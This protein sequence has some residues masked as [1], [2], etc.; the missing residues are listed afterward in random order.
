LYECPYARS[1][2]NYAWFLATCP[3][4][5]FRDPAQS[6]RLAQAATGLAPESAEYWNTLGVARYRSGQWKEALAALDHSCQLA[7]GGTAFDFY[8][9]AMAHYQLS[10]KEKAEEYYKKANQDSGGSTTLLEPITHVRTEAEALL[11]KK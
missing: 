1:M 5:E 11:G 8:F 10:H 3:Q 6:V 7:G 4:V 2:N 9:L